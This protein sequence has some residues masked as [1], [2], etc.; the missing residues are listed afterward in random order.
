MSS[1]LTSLPRDLQDVLGL[2]WGEE[3]EWVEESPGPRKGRLGSAAPVAPCSLCS[4]SLGPFPAILGMAGPSLWPLAPVGLWLWNQ[5]SNPE[6][7]VLLE[8]WINRFV[9]FQGLEL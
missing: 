6:S 2:G 4:V 7:H 1:W 9:Y 3:F 5:A 8:L